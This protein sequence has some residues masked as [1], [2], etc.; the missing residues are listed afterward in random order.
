MDWDG[1]PW[2]PEAEGA[3]V[4]ATS[5][6]TTAI[7][8][9][10]RRVLGCRAGGADRGSEGPIG[11]LWGRLKALRSRVSER[12]GRNRDKHQRHEDAVVPPG[13]LSDIVGE[14]FI[15]EGE[16]VFDWVHHD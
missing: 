12:L 6:L 8:G 7:D 10:G 16:L 5:G 9:E 15:G 2:E 1:W 3:D 14:A 11:S 13:A 4:L